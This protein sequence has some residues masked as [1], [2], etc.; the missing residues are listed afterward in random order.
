MIRRQG[1]QVKSFGVLRQMQKRNKLSYLCEVEVV[2]GLGQVA[3][4]ELKQHLGKRIN[5][6]L[7]VRQ[8]RERDTIRF[9]C[10]GNLARILQ[11]KTVLSAY[12]VCEFAGSNPSVLLQ[13]AALRQ[14]AQ[15]VEWVKAVAPAATYRSFGISA[16][17]A[18]SPLMR[19]FQEALVKQLGLPD[20]RENCDLLLRLRR[21]IDQ[22]KGWEVLIRL[23]PRPLST[24]FWRVHNVRGAL[25]ATIAH[26]MVMLTKPTRRDTFLNIACGSGTLLIERMLHSPVQRIIGCDSDAKMIEHAAANLRACG[27]QDAVELYGW[28]VRALNLPTASIDAICA[29]LPFGFAVGSHEDNLDLYPGLLQETARVA[30]S[31]ARFVVITH[32]IRLLQRLLEETDRWKLI[33]SIPIQL[34]ELH[35]RIFVLQRTAHPLLGD[36]HCV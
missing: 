25:N 6:E 9:R 28:D 16:A 13:P 22:Q 32:E 12:L 33:Q 29:D 7:I 5:T 35:P 3:L 1:D 2:L 21:S 20:R 31:G 11:L 4:S 10:Q 17:G 23:S 19:Q 34:K 26:C 24:R 30:K 18:H 36:R 8:T 14:I 27:F 15:Q